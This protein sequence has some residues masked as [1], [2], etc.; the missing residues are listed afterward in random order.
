[1]KLQAVQ[2]QYT[3]GGDYMTKKLKSPI[4]FLTVFAML[5]SMLLYFPAGTFGGFDLG[6]RASAA[7]S[8][9]V[10]SG[11]GTEANPYKIGTVSELYWFMQNAGNTSKHYMLTN[12][13]TLNSRV[14]AAD[15]SPNSGPFETWTPVS[16]F[17]GVFDGNDKTISGL[18]INSTSDYM[19]F[20]GECGQGNDGP[21]I[22]KLTIIDS[23]VKG[24]EKVGGI[25]ANIDGG[26]LEK[27]TFMGTVEGTKSVGGVCGYSY[28]A[29]VYSGDIPSGSLLNCASYGNV[30]GNERIGG[31]VGD[32]YS[33]SLT[34]CKHTATGC[35]NYA[36]V[37]GETLVG[38]L[39]GF[40]A[41]SEINLIDCHNFGN[42]TA[43]GEN[44]GGLFGGSNGAFRGTG[45]NAI[46]NII[47]CT[48]S[49]NVVG[50]NHVGG[51][52]GCTYDQNAPYRD[53]HIKNCT[54]SGSV[55]GTNF[56]GGLVSYLLS[57]STI[58]NCSNSGD[59]SGSEDVGG[60]CG[61][62]SSTATI[63]DCFNTGTITGTSS[64]IG[65]IL[66]EAYTTSIYRCY[67]EG[68]IVGTG[69][70]YVGGIY[71]GEL[72]SPCYVYDSYNLGNVTG[73]KYV[74]GIGGEYCT[75]K[76]C[77]SMGE[78]TGETNIS[79]ICCPN[80]LSNAATGCAFYGDSTFNS[81]TF[82]DEGLKKDLSAFTSG[83]VAYLMQEGGGKWG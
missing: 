3:I 46:S 7:V 6:L 33:S 47:N 48:N 10:P 43:T 29:G 14:L 64:S 23:Y 40:Y 15:G 83:E 36:T 38:G 72:Y 9:T 63:S 77:F 1:M 32:I 73:K 13:I 78:V 37:S 60:V 62:G 71:G 75:A 17:R 55:T 4:A 44:A 8:S 53:L 49:G 5:L 54:N 34:S 26:L 69:A 39:F 50:S 19:G 81:N 57:D 59:V 42:V 21:T 51:I 2:K 12:N 79:G 67:N 22:K 74:S 80:T 56:V 24:G 27:C 76:Y 18:Y 52:C 68:N 45:I 61:Y 11:D 70:Q 66:G 25:I 31:I 82:R 20:F 16:D 30:S 28:F 65:G 58:E 41:F 35:K